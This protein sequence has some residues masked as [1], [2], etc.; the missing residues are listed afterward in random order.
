MFYATKHTLKECS[1]LSDDE[2]L[3]VYDAFESETSEIEINYQQ[4]NEDNEYNKAME[5][6]KIWNCNSTLTVSYD[7]DDIII[8]DKTINKNGSIINLIS[9]DEIIS[10]S[11]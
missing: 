10:I 4:R 7:W 6:V 11:S 1:L 2:H 5:K 3:P 9:D 8:D